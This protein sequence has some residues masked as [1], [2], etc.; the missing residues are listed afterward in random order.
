MISR[1][2]CLSNSASVPQSRKFEDERLASTLWAKVLV[3]KQDSFGVSLLPWRLGGSDGAGKRFHSATAAIRAASV[4]GFQICCNNL[5][6][7]PA[8]KGPEIALPVHVAE[9]KSQGYGTAISAGIAMCVS[10]RS[11]WCTMLQDEC[12]CNQKWGR[13]LELCFVELISLRTISPVQPFP[14]ALLRS[15]SFRVVA[16][17]S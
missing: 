12:C 2:E 7:R 13:Q 5:R 14:V 10:E 3:F 15:S 6:T 4:L 1:T 9:A 17:L 16:I 8:G 11:H